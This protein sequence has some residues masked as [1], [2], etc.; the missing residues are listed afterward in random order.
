MATRLSRQIPSPEEYWENSREIL[1]GSDRSVVIILAAEVERF[2]ESAILAK[3]INADDKEK[4][5]GQDGP[6]ATFSRKIQIGYAMGLYNSEVRDDLDR[7]RD[8][9]NDF[10]HSVM[11]ISFN[12]PSVR[13]RCLKFKQAPPTSGSPTLLRWGLSQGQGPVDIIGLEDSPDKAA[14]NRFIIVCNCTSAS[15]YGVITNTALAAAS[16]NSKMSHYRGRIG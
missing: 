9:R 12:T 15:L 2:L 3:F 5:I 8:V 11:P 1:N 13:D 4:L 10:A 16:Q 7:I 14:R 6:L